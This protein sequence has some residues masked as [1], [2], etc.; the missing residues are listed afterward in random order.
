MVRSTF[1][2]FALI[3]SSMEATGVFKVR[4]VGVVPSKDFQLGGEAHDEL[5]VQLKLGDQLTELEAKGQEFSWKNVVLFKHTVEEKLIL[6]LFGTA[7][8][9]KIGYA[10]ILLTPLA[11]IPDTRHE[12]TVH[13]VY[14]H[15][16]LAMED[17]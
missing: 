6:R 8:D 12:V 3:I 13:A 7:D 1:L 17:K 9:P 16:N 5:K 4:V 2:D 14:R 11:K 10:E 15:S